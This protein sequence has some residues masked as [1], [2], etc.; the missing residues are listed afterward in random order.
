MTGYR[1]ILA[2]FGVFGALALVEFIGPIVRGRPF[3][4]GDMGSFFFPQRFFFAQSVRNGDFPLWNPLLFDGTP[5]LAEPQ[6]AVLYPPTWLFVLWPGPETI[7]IT[8]VLHIALAGVGTAWLTRDTL[9]TSGWACFCAGLV[10]AFSGFFCMHM[11][12]LNQV[13]ACAWSPWVLW[14]AVRWLN[15]SGKNAWVLLAILYAVQFL[16]GG[17]ENS[18]YLTVILIGLALFHSGRG[19]AESVVLG[20]PSWRCRVGIAAGLIAALFLGAGLAGVQL[21]PTFELAGY[22]VRSGGLP[23]EISGQNS[24]PPWRPLVDVFVPSS[25]GYYGPGGHRTG[26]TPPSELANMVGLAATLLALYAAITLWKRPWIRQWTG[27]AL[28]AMVFAWGRFTPL[29]DILYPLGFKYFRNPARF[30]FLYALAAAVLAAAGAERVFESRQPFLSSRWHRAASGVVGLAGLFLI[31]FLSRW[32]PSDSEEQEGLQ[33]L[34]AWDAGFDLLALAAG[35]AALSFRLGRC[36]KA[37]ATLALALPLLG[38]TRESEFNNLNDPDQAKMRAHEEL[39]DR[40]RRGLGPFRVLT[41]HAYDM[42]ENRNMLYGLPDVSGY[43]GGL[44]PLANYEALKRRMSPDSHLA[45]THGRRLLDILGARFILEDDGHPSGEE[46]SPVHARAGPCQARINVAARPRLSFVPQGVELP[47]EEILARMAAGKW[48]PDREAFFISTTASGATESSGPGHDDAPTPDGGPL[49]DT[50]L[51][52]VEWGNDFTACDVSVPRP[53][54]LVLSDAYYSG[55]RVT[56]NGAETELLRANWLF[57]GVALSA[58]RQRVEFRYRP[59]SLHAGLAL[60]ILSLLIL[61][62][63]YRL[64]GIPHAQA[65]F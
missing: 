1:R 25:W 17:A 33:H 28:A 23:A 50:R 62:L 55:W 57:R 36:R 24:L 30:V 4:R 27:V 10:Y 9:G 8:L 42:R 34:M 21:L 11:G 38:F 22:S 56:V 19:Q 37:L 59:A 44:L 18:F 15:G 53:G 60:S 58:G 40:L 39:A 29:Y 2:L 45:L 6:N 12:H 3:L 13:M 20:R 43:E 31:L 65:L 64:A 52:I 7:W 49:A 32:L 51:E 41:H 5:F 16:P 47:E 61:F 54:Y 14:A 63:V 46:S 48:D 26:E 35:Y